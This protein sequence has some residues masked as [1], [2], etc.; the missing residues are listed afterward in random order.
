MLLILSDYKSLRSRLDRSVQVET[1]N[2]QRCRHR[3]ANLSTE[4]TE[5]L[6]EFDHR[7]LR[8]SSSLT[9]PSSAIQM[10]FQSEINAQRSCKNYW[11]DVNLIR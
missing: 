10:R 5:E 2:P 9:E 7:T 1:F 6:E 4:P 8:A 11:T 3:L